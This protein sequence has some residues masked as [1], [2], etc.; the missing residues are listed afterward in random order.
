MIQFFHV[1]KAYPGDPPVLQDINLNVEKGEFVF[2]TGPSGAGKTT[3]LKLIFCGEKATKGQILVGGKNIA[4]IRESAVPYLRRNIGVVFQDFKLLP[5][6]SVADNVGFTLDVLGVPRA[7]GR[8]K[9]HRMLKR[10]GLEHKANSLPLR[11]SG[12]E[13]Q[14]VV[15][16]RALVNDPTIL[17]ADEPTG[18]LDPALTVEIMD[19][20]TDIN[21]RGTTVMVATHDAT[22]LSRY[23]KRTV[24]LERGL[25]VS[26][27][28]GVKA[29]RRMLV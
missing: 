8:E 18:N 29:A 7:E 24:R 12:G 9:V 11:L 2:L 4:R 5:H 6:R 10:V 14:R 19:L 25:I 21:I 13:Q 20:L 15:I 27:E 1:Y 16:A 26:D 22:L 17:L 28:D 23:Q 3:L